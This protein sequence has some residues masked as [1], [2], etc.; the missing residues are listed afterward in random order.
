LEPNVSPHSQQTTLPENGLFATAWLATP[1]AALNL[2]LQGVELVRVD[3]GGMTV[4]DVVLRNLAFVDLLLLRQ[5][6]HR[7]ALLQEGIALVFLVREYQAHR[8]GLPHS[9]AA[10][11]EDAVRRLAIAE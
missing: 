10:R 2:G 5:E 3:D 4:L 6:V 11:R 9:L 1:H 8:G 7:G